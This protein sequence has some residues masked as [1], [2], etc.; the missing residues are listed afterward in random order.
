[1]ENKPKLSIVLATLNEE[2]YIGDCLRSVR[3]I[4]DEMIVFDESSVDKTKEIAEGLGAKVFT[5]VHEPHFHITKQKAINK[6]QGEWIL[7]LDADERVTLVL[8]EEI[9][10][11][12]SM[13]QGELKN[14]T[15]NPKKE[16]LFKRQQALLV[17]RDGE[18]GKPGEIVAFF[19][20]RK[21]FFLGK[22]IVHGGLYPDG[23]IRLFKKG[24]AN[25]PS[26]DVHA[27]MKID[28]E[29]AWL[30]NDLEHNDSP[31]FAKYL[32]RMNRYTSLHAGELKEKKVKKNFSSFMY[33][34]FFKPMGVFC[35]LYFR[36]KGILD[37]GRGFLW[38]LF[39]SLHY[40][41][42][43]FKYWTGKIDK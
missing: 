36:H 20:P 12:I 21:N 34:V 30:E 9:K 22:A 8:S 13:T 24:R 14:R 27:Q 35:S 23:V 1:M 2:G 38:S 39:S 17:Q 5:V 40:P 31:T 19:I 32:K 11:V 15:I 43:Y 42:A 7:Q 18:I 10:K 25:L 41:V 26:E 29:V 28:G 4:A 37:G 6:A 33:Y 16:R 3:G